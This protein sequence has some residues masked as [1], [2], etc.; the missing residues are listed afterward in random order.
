MPRKKGEYTRA[1]ILLWKCLQ[2][3]LDLYK[4]IF[5]FGDIIDLLPEAYYHF[6]EEEW[7]SFRTSTD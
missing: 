4:S 5:S 3:C 7:V 6:Q 1:L 2:R